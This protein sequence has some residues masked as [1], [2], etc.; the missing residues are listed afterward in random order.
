MKVF[1]QKSFKF[2]RHYPFSCL[3]IV[4]IWVLCLIPLPETPLDN[5]RFIDKWTHF[6]FYGGL[7]S[8]LWAEYGRRHSSIDKQRT[9]LWI[10]IAPVVMGGLIEIVQA[11][12]THGV[13]NG[14]VTDWLA[15]NIG[16]L[17]GQ[18]IGIPLALYLSR[19]NKVR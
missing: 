1:M 15:D 11:T 2:I 10:V 18:L 13:R 3:I 17:I 14:D 9:L 4:A 8:V 12:C 16:V 6:I 7:C 19:L 5:V